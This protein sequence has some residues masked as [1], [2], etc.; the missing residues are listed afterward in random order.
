VRWVQHNFRPVYD[1]DGHWPGRRGSN[2]DIT[3]RKMVI[4]I[5]ERQNRTLSFLQEIAQEINGELEISTLLHNIMQ[6]AV[7]LSRADRG[8]RFTC[9][10]KTKISSA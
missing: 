5:L 7:D 10:K 9:L 8:G 3:G 6:L 2:R 1:A 4:E